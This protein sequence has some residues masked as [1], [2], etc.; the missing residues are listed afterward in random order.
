VIKFNYQIPKGEKTMKKLLSIIL[1]ILM[2]VTTI[3]MAFAADTVASEAFGENGNNLTWTLDTEGVLTISGEGGMGTID[4]GS[5]PWNA[6][7]DEIKHVVIEEGV[8]DVGAY[9]FYQYSNLLS[10]YIANS[11]KIIND[12]AFRECSSATKIFIGSG[13]EKMTYYCFYNTNCVV[14][15]NGTSA[16]WY[17]I[18]EDYNGK[19]RSTVH[20][21]TVGS[22]DATCADDG[23]T[24]ACV[25]FS[26]D[27]VFGGVI[28][29][30]TGEHTRVNDV[31]TVCGDGCTHP[32]WTNAF[33]DVC[34]DLCVH[35]SYTDS[36]CDLCKTAC[37][38]EYKN[39]ICTLCSYKCEHN[40]YYGSCENCGI[41]G[42]ECTDTIVWTLDDDGVFT[43]SGSGDMPYYDYYRDVPWFDDLRD[44]IKTV[45]VSEGITSICDS[46]FYMCSNLTSVTLP[47]T[48]NKIDGG[49]FCDCSSLE[50][51]IIP[52]GVTTLDA[53][54]FAWCGSLKT[55]HYLGSENE[56]TIDET[57]NT[58][59]E[60]ILHFCEHETGVEASCTANGFA[61][62]WYCAE[63]DKHIKVS[64]VIPATNHKDTLVQ[65]DAKAPTCTEIGW[66][67]Y[68]YCTACDYTTYVEL[69][70]DPDAHT[71]LE[72]VKEN[73]VVSKC[74]VAGSYDL[75]VYCDDCGAELDRDTKTVDAL[76]HSFTKYE[77]TE[78]AKC[79]V[80]GKEVATCD[81]GCGATDEKAIAALTH[82]DADG[83]YKC[84]FGCGHEFEKPEA[85]AEDICPDCGRPVHDDTL[86]QSFVCWIIMLVNLIKSMF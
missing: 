86:V 69:P 35:P 53:S 21:L 74:G 70:A 31:C 24:D 75:V 58:L 29:P 65:V 48:L 28:I 14:H 49:A 5:Q 37:S 56:L 62:G 78:E 61:D 59:N 55:I 85:P 43:L 15:Y 50:D 80:E 41:A 83:D 60:G 26:C 30:A 79:G 3:P 19:P 57:N 52:S 47:D 66:E 20:Y 11:V 17:A 27:A 32:T 18:D 54:A 44:Y 64:E 34:G 33:C 22:K 40:F 82:K 84:D 42:G 67:A 77:V 39:G 46:A 25:C 2:I 68:E 38:H 63:C 73:E 10:A 13:V 45:I 76:K 81:N 16:M 51:I 8:T 7:K 72:A 6:Y 23:Y 71:P 12:C 4:Y 9:A 1:A 36:L